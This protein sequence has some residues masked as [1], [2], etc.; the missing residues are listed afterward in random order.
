[1]LNVPQQ[2]YE[3]MPIGVLIGA[4]LGLGTLRAAASSR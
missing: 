2:V 1:L 4:L 3:T